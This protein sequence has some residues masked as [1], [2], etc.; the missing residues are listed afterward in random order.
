[1]CTELKRARWCSFGF[2]SHL[3]PV[4]SQVGYL[5]GLFDLGFACSIQGLC[6]LQRPLINRAVPII[7]FGQQKLN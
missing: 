3:G 2:D 6:P 7:F 5:L 4:I 1:M